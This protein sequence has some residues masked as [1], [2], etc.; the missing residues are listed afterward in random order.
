MLWMYFQNSS[1]SITRSGG[2]EGFFF[3]LDSGELQGPLEVKLTEM[4]D[5]SLRLVP[6]KLLTLKLVY[7]LELPL[8]GR[9]QVIVC[10]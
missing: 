1:Y 10:S 9:R 2:T 8:A 7:R 3:T 6:L 4:L 5:S